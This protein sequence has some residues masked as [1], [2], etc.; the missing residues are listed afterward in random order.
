MADTIFKLTVSGRK[1]LLSLYLTTDFIKHKHECEALLLTAFLT[2]VISS[3]K[4]AAQ[5]GSSFCGEYPRRMKVLTTRGDE[6]SGA[7][8][9]SCSASVTADERGG[10][11]AKLGHAD[12]AFLGNAVK[13][14]EEC[15]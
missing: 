11:V 7:H 1:V 6:C 14:L 5:E 4:H 9:A 12:V 10:E 3:C 8:G 15:G 2:L 13:S